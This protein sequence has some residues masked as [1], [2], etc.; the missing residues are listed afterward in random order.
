MAWFGP[1]LIRIPE[2]YGPVDKATLASF[3]GTQ[4]GLGDEP[5]TEQHEE[6]ARKLNIKPIK[7]NPDPEFIITHN[8]VYCG[9]V[10]FGMVVMKERAGSLL[11]NYHVVA[12]LV[13]HP[14][15]SILFLF[16]CVFM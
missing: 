2:G 6:N 11:N 15:V 12:T 14:Y 13:A 5:P 8:P 10:A 16:S 4:L 3:V 9:N 1:S 7:P